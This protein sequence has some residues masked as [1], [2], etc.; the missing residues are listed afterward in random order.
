VWRP[1]SRA[2]APPR[3]SPQDVRPNALRTHL[4]AISGGPILGGMAHR[5]PRAA[6][7]ARP[8]GGLRRWIAPVAVLA[9][10][11]LIRL[12]LI[13]HTEVI[14][15]D[16]TDY[17]RMARA[18]RSDPMRVVRGFRRHA[19]YPAVVSTV[20]RVYA[21]LRGAEAASPASWERAAQITSLLAAVG[22]T[23][24]LWAFARSVFTPQ[25][26]WIAALLFTVTRK[27]A[28]IGADALSDALYVCL[29]LWAL[30]LAMGALERIQRRSRLALLGGLGA[31]LCAGGAYL[32]RPEGLLV[33]IPAAALFP[34]YWLYR[35]KGGRLALG[36]AAVT[37]AAALAAASP[38]MIAIGGITRKKDLSDFIRIAGGA[39]PMFAAVDLSGLAAGVHRLGSELVEALHVAPA[40][41]VGACLATWV[42]VRILRLGLPAAVRIFPRRAGAFLI[43]GVAAIFGPLLIAQYTRH[44]FLSHRYLFLLAA[45]LAGP[46]GAGLLILIEW[47]RIGA[48]RL[49]WAPDRFRILPALAAIAV[50]AGLTAHALRPLHEGKAYHRQAGEFLAQRAAAK[51]DRLVTDSQWVLHY[52]QLPGG[53]AP[54]GPPPPA[55]ALPTPQNLLR[56]LRRHRTTWLAL[57]DRYARICRPAAGGADLKTLLA[58][59]AF[60]KVCSFVQ[61]GVSRPDSVVVYQV[62]LDALPQET[63]PRP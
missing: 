44:G 8:A 35:R 16:G 62:D 57:S 47:C 2:H 56:D 29:G 42:G 28:G 13:Q 45:L 41:L 19:G 53:R 48:A 30:V 34:A 23:A 63:P 24:A 55:R 60:R 38:Y 18:W 49:G 6:L 59:P 3:I 10:C 25:I 50:A 51:A 39:G 43:V 21:P 37:I 54:T 1:P 52:A 7:R 40:I 12:W 14:A 61:Q 33:A 20:H 15:K 17:V 4:P 31:G 5:E 9:V 22:A 11:A 32:V 46:A 27:W 26:A 58:P 36:C